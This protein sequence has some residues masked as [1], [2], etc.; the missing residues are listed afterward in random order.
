MLPIENEKKE[1]KLILDKTQNLLELGIINLILL[2]KYKF[3][4]RK[5]YCLVIIFLI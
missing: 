3:F 5:K 1:R 2:L 4:G